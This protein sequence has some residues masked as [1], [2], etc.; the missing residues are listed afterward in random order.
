MTNGGREMYRFGPFLI[1]A[2]ARELYRGEALVPLTSKA[3]DL[4]LTLV[5]GVGRTVTKSELMAALWPD[6]AV[7]ESNL[8]QTVFVL[9]KALGEDSE[10]TG[11]IRTV[12]RQG[13]RFVAPVI[14]DGRPERAEADD[15]ERRRFRLRP[16]GIAFGSIA[17]VAGAI[18]GFISGALLWR[19]TRPTDRPPAPGLVR[20][21]I[22][23][24]NEARNP[25][26]F[27]VSPDGRYLAFTAISPSG[28]PRR[29]WL[30]AMSSLEARPV[31]DIGGAGIPFWSPD[32]RF[33][34]FHTP[35]KLLRIDIEGD[36]PQKVCDCT[37]TNGS[38]N[39][40]G[41]ILFEDLEGHLMRVPAG[42]GVPVAVSNTVM[43]FPYF[44]PDGRHFLYLGGPQAD[45][46]SV[47]SFDGKEAAPGRELAIAPYAAA[48][49]PPSGS[50]PGY[51]LFYR[52]ETLLAQPFDARRM[53]MRGDPLP[54]AQHLQFIGRRA[55]FTVS[56]DNVL[57]YKVSAAIEDTRLTWFDSHGTSLRT[58]GEPEPH[59]SVALSLDSSRAAFVRPE[60]RTNP[61]SN[62][63]LLDLAR[64]GS[65]Q[66][67]TSNT[68][69]VN[70]AVW[71]RDGRDIVYSVH[72]EGQDFV[73]RKSVLG[74][75]PELL[76]DAPR[77]VPNSLSPDGRFLLY[78]TYAVTRSVDLLLLP[79]KGERKPVPYLTT[80]FP[81][82][83]GRFSP[84]GHWVAYVS[85]ESGHDE[86]NVKEFPTSSALVAGSAVSKG[87]GEQ[88]HWR[89]NSETLYRG[90]NRNLM[91][92]DITTGGL[93]AGEPRKLFQLPLGAEAWDVTADGKKFL[94]AVPL[95]QSAP[96]P[97]TVVL[98]WQWLL[99][100]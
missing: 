56:A 26:T 20:F 42:G 76:L 31:P 64:G 60:S 32:S 100:K 39:K 2:N 85:S 36:P 5:R 88:P 84:D 94:V 8:T 25:G 73:Y 91:A 99:K 97:F 65:P 70:A 14:V 16:R 53:E 58:V 75:D 7:E 44:L 24:P 28:G 98:N 18:A 72:R 46:I 35:D 55:L 69:F 15:G 54:V 38:W 78:A 10:E 51:L 21:E 89:G 83:G 68:G 59:L 96:P 27:E 61:D 77:A 41:V 6:T 34:A 4:L 33:V 40:D 50:G 52:D 66:P 47:G 86:I 48:Y 82:S 9:R 1:E 17:F 71:S 95:A 57:I 81:E 43:H 63:W 23:V 19:A 30:R 80:P 79:L 92:V 87:G 49:T 74:G 37:G 93:R 3:F 62:L 13:Y 45:R 22:P 11:Y 29:L 67:F 90:A 12:P